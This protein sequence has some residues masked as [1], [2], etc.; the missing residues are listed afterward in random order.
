MEHRQMTD[1]RGQQRRGPVG[2]A[3]DGDGRKCPQLNKFRAI[4]DQAVGAQELGHPHVADRLQVRLRR[5]LWAGQL[6]AGVRLE[7]PVHRDLG[8]DTD[9]GG[10]VE[11]RVGLTRPLPVRA[12]DRQQIVG[13]RCVVPEERHL[14][15]RRRRH[16]GAQTG[17]VSQVFLAVGIDLGYPLAALTAAGHET[18]GAHD[19]H[20]RH[21]QHVRG[22]LTHP[23]EDHDRDHADHAAAH[24][25]GHGLLHARGRDLDPE[26]IGCG[27]I[28]LA[29]CQPR[30]P[31]DRRGELLRRHEPC[32]L[33]TL[34]G[35][36]SAGSV[37][38][39]SSAASFDNTGPSTSSPTTCHGAFTEPDKPRFFGGIVIRDAVPS[40]PA[41]RCNTGSRPPGDPAT[42]AGR[43]ARLRCTP[44][45]RRRSGRSRC[46]RPTTG[47]VAGGR[48]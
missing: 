6:A 42:A 2:V 35:C 33:S 44:L 13:M 45:R 22:Q 37:S 11:V 3:T 17:Q 12:D 18:D 39:S 32:L 47:S 28:D 19:H 7:Q 48:R 15:R 30:P 24:D 41:G 26:V 10:G 38:C 16:P 36:G 29:R 34:R 43:T 31:L 40:R 23:G 27:D 4:L 21:H 8:A 46:R 9:P 20:Q 1:H 25:P 5:A 14:S